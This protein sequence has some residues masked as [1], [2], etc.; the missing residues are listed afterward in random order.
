MNRISIFATVTAWALLAGTR[1][2][3][4]ENAYISEDLYVYLHRGPGREFKITGTLTAGTPVTV[5]ARDDETEYA[6]VSDGQGKAGWVE[7]RVLSDS[8]SRR[9]RLEEVERDLEK[10]QQTH[11]GSGAKL[12]GYE[13]E[14]RRLKAQNVQL[15]GKNG[16]LES[17]VERFRN[18]LAALD[19]DQQMSWFRNGALV[20]GAGL[21][22]GLLIP[23]LSLPK[24]RT[25]GW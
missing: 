14:L 7:S 6:E 17:E 1:A 16:A 13:E 5:T 12:A 24:R 15:Q 18:E 10:L 25:N 19:E 23:R 8:V 9:A 11:V 21:L 20:L 3:A 22:L 2:G 4:G